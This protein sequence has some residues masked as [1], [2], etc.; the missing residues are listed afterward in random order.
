MDNPSPSLC[1][2]LCD[3]QRQEVRDNS[4]FMS[5]GMDAGMHP[6]PGDNL[7]DRDSLQELL[8]TD[9]GLWMLVSRRQGRGRGRGGADGLGGLGSRAVHANSCDNNDLLP[10]VSK[11]KNNSVCLTR[12]GS[13]MRDRGGSTTARVHTPRKATTK[14][15]HPSKKETF[16]T[17]QETDFSLDAP[18]ESELEKGSLLYV[19]LHLISEGALTTVYSHCPKETYPPNIIYKPISPISSKGKKIIVSETVK[20]SGNHPILRTSK[21]LIEGFESGGPSESHQMIIDKV[22]MALMPPSQSPRDSDQDMS[23]S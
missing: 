22:T 14:V 1:Y 21:N 13:S 23:D 15:A 20:T 7:E 19:Y 5:D 8:K 10:N 4:D 6:R 17:S 12:G 2:D 11:S 18:L 16:L 3:R 9:Y